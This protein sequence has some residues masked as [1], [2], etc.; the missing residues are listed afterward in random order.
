MGQ[1]Y[2]FNSPLSFNTGV[3]WFFGLAA[4]LWAFVLATF[5]K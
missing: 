1:A 2:N 5:M 3:Y 4:K